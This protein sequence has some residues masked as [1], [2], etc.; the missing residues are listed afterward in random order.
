MQ[1]NNKFNLR[2]I[3]IISYKFLV[4]IIF[5]E[6]FYLIINIYYFFFRFTKTIFFQLIFIPIMQCFGLIFKDTFTLMGFSATDGS[7]IINTNAAFGMM[8][9][10]INGPLLRIY[11][12]RKV[13]VAGATF[14]SV[15]ILLTA[16]AN[17]FTFFI[18]TYGFLTG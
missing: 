11:G 9:G 13:S 2:M 17:T 16:F 3:I 18:I 1:L 12:Y 7:V 8:M 14:I 15:G 4:V 10:L 6:Y 5:V